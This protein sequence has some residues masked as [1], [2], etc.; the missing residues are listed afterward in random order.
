MTN[1]DRNKLQKQV[2]DLT[3]Y[4]QGI[5]ST[6]FVEGGYNM[7]AVI[8]YSYSTLTALTTAHPAANEELGVFGMGGDVLYVVAQDENNAKTWKE[9]GVFP[10]TG[11]AGKDGVDGKQGPIGPQGPTGNDGKTGPQGVKGDTGPQGPQGPKG[12]T[13]PQGPIG[14]QGPAGKDGRGLEN[15]T[16]FSFRNAS[17]VS[18]NTTT[19]ATFIGKARFNDKD[20]VISA[21]TGTVIL[22]IKGGNGITVDAAAGN[23]AIQINVDGAIN[24]A[25]NQSLTIGDEIEITNQGGTKILNLDKMGIDQF[26]FNV[27]GTP[28]PY[29]K[30]ISGNA[31]I[32]DMAP[33]LYWTFVNGYYEI[34]DVPTTSTSGT[35]P[36][37]DGWTYLK[38][39]PVELRLLF[40][41]EFYQLSDNQHTT[42]T[43]VYS[44]TGYEGSQLII[45]T[46]TITISTRGWVLTTIKPATHI[47]AGFNDLTSDS[48]GNNAIGT[49]F[50]S[51]P[52]TNDVNTTDSIIAAICT[53]TY[54]PCTGYITYNGKKEPIIAVDSYDKQAHSIVVYTPKYDI[55]AGGISCFTGPFQPDTFTLTY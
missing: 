27:N 2:E 4:C 15:V 9:L 17:I 11:P 36:D 24:L 30:H 48:A 23:N 22:P 38:Q 7:T 5:Q 46:I 37:D 41:N 3:E 28:A 50:Y 31:V 16:G 13:G 20:G 43:L 32:T 47:A 6:R 45:K 33:G 34:D 55:N 26:E 25:E 29:Y 19:G 54:F 42:G 49:I 40:N 12:D 44:H 8:K 51:I 10:A 1:L 14:P 39:N 35:I 53:N 18:Y 21:P 52:L